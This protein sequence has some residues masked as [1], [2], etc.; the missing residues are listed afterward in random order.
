MFRSD[1]FFKIDVQLQEY[2][3]KKRAVN[4]PFLGDS[5]EPGTIHLLVP[6]MKGGNYGRPDN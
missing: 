3:E 4:L 1:F 2:S 5:E 6:K